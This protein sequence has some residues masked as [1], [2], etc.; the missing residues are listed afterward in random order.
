[1]DDVIG[2]AGDGFPTDD[3][4]PDDDTMSA[5]SDEKDG[6]DDD[7]EDEETDASDDADTDEDDSDDADVADED[8]ADEADADD[9][10]EDESDEVDADDPDADDSDEDDVEEMDDDLVESAEEEDPA[11]LTPGPDAEADPYHAVMVVED[12]ET[13]GQ[14][15][16]FGGRMMLFAD[17][18]LAQKIKTALEGSDFDWQ[19]RGVTADHLDALRRL[20]RSR[21]IQLFVVVGFTDT[22][23]VEAVPIEKDLPRRK[24]PKPPPLPPKG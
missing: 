10:D 2:T 20:S 14:I 3:T 19:L 8:E 1:M 17:E 4:H 21:E 15:W 5:A 18:E 6:S 16:T 23:Q 22:G 9:S 11:I 24:G 7:E 13:T 12:G